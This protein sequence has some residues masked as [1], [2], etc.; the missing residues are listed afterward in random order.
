M[1]FKRLLTILALLTSVTALAFTLHTTTETIA[2]VDAAMASNYK[3]FDWKWSGY[4]DEKFI[5]NWP[6]TPTKVG[7]R[8]S[9][10]RNGTVFLTI[11]DGAAV[12][13]IVTTG[14]Q[15]VCTVLR[16]QMPPSGTY[17]AEFV[18][19][20]TTYTD[21]NTR[22]IAKGKIKVDHSV[23]ENTTQSTWTNPLAG[24]VIGP[25]LHTLSALSE[26][27]FATS[28]DAGDLTGVLVSGGNLTISA[29]TG[30]VPTIG[31]SS[32]QIISAAGIGAFDTAAER[33][34][35]YEALAN[36]YTDAKNTTFL[37]I[38]TAAERKT[39]YA[40]EANAFTD[41][42]NTT[43]A[44][45]DTAGE[46]K[47]LYAAEANAYTDAKNTTFLSIDTAAERKT[48]YAAEANAY[49]D[50]KN[51]IFL[52]IDTAAERA[53]SLPQTTKGDILVRNG[54]VLV[55]VGVGDDDQVLTADAGEDSGVKWADAGG[56]GSAGGY[57]WISA[58]QFMSFD[59]GG[60]PAYDEW[61]HL[62]HELDTSDYR[63]EGTG[64]HTTSATEQTGRLRATIRTPEGST[65]WGTANA[66]V[67]K[68]WAD[69]D[70]DAKIIDINIWGRNTAGTVNVVEADSTDRTVTTANTPELIT[71]DDSALTSTTIYE[72]YTIELI[73]AS[74][75]SDA[76]WINGITLNF[77]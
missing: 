10:P 56:G 8:L 31:L 65:A 2:D 52:G 21:L 9:Y 62:N 32:A 61:A 7:L 6:I 50:A 38:D 57:V 3:A 12:T 15:S 14:A 43:L 64:L 53:A 54:S 48:L 27:P 1:K 51:T 75:N 67:I 39:L 33:K 23:W 42:K 58:S 72:Y 28:A 41:A 73:V 68:V 40:A 26:W 4:N 63:L 22:V 44:S 47:T 5:V 76:M 74:A 71:I 45:I 70:T 18:D 13:N 20:Y 25:P 16:T 46:R 11:L 60:S 24:T 55:R 36:A 30:P 59:T 19:Y 66:I 34:T 49:T 17:Y 37:S 29:A 77:D 35:L 69:D